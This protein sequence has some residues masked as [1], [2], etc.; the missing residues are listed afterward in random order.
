L[1]QDNRFQTRA[2]ALG[3]LVPYHLATP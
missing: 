1:V 2:S 3:Q